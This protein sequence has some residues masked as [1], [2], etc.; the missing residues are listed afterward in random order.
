MAA[1]IGFCLTLTS[2]V[3]PWS[4]RQTLRQYCAVQKSAART[5]PEHEYEH[6]LVGQCLTS[7]VA[8]LHTGGAAGSTSA[9]IKARLAG[10]RAAREAELEEMRRVNAAQREQ[11]KVRLGCVYLCVHALHACTPSF[12]VLA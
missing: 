4:S 5:N 11:R 7:V 10:M 6:E 9:A 1:C 3:V 2:S 8:V 12:T